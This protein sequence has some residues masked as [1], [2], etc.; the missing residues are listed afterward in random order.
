MRRAAA[1]PLLARRRDRGDRLAVREP[2]TARSLTESRR[3]A[4][5]GRAGASLLDVAA[6]LRGDLGRRGGLPGRDRPLGCAS[7]RLLAAALCSRSAWARG[8]TRRSPRR[9]PSCARSPR[10][11]RSTPRPARRR[12]TRR[13]RLPRSAGPARAAEAANAGRTAPDRSSRLG[14]RCARPGARDPARRQRRTG[15]R[16]HARRGRSADAGRRGAGRPGPAR[17]GAWARATTSHRLARRH[18]PGG[19]LGRAARAARAERRDACLDRGLVLL[20]AR[21]ETFDGPRA[22]ETPRVALQRA[23]IVLG[24]IAALGRPRCG[25]TGWWPT[26]R[27]RCDSRSLRSPPARSA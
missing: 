22:P 14:G 26:R 16:T 24:T 15:A 5:A 3:S 7:A 21:R 8:S 19:A 10:N 6:D 20:V 9:S 12:C 4:A 25:S 23:A 18:R 17:G 27:S 11:R 1:V 13:P 2:G